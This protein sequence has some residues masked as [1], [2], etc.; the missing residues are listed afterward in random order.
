MTPSVSYRDWE[1]IDYRPV[2]EAHYPHALLSELPRSA[3][4]LEIGCN[5]GV[6]SCFVATERPDVTVHG[7]DVNV[8]AIAAA[9]LRATQQ[10]LD[11]MQFD[12]ADVTKFPRRQYDA[13]ITIRVLTCFPRTK[14]WD[15]L[16]RVIARAVRPG[17]LW[18]AVDYLYDPANPAYRDR[19]RAGEAE[20]FRRGSFPVTSG[21]QFVAHH[22]TEEEIPCLTQ[23]FEN[24]RLRRFESLSMNGN[25]A[26]MFELL[27]TRSGEAK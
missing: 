16:L 9:R 1:S 26:A 18:Y 20:G 22:H 23:P 5:D 14:E 25:R 13:V 11:N 21:A 15:A 27:A 3:S 4:V 17:G 19:Y 6:V 8:R 7:I 2:I 12:V 10:Q 24:I